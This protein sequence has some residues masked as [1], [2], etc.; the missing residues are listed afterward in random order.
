[1]FV[2]IFR[3]KVKQFD[4]E[5]SATAARMRELA[6]TKFG[7]IEFHA[8]TEGDHEIALSYWPDEVSIKAWRMY[9]EHLAAQKLG[10]ER[11]YE[12]YS[13]QVAEIGR[14]YRSR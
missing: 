4:S 8:V 11:W 9:P 1:M 5:Y 10:K 6:L 3:A 7:C 2:V 12:S 14:E 13:V